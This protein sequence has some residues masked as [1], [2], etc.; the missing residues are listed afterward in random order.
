MQDRLLADAVLLLHGAFILFVLAGG[1]LV[2]RW[3]RLAWL[4]LP[5][6]AWAIW[7]EV[8][9]GI[10]PLTPLE[11]Q[12]RRAA[13]LAGFGGGFIEHYLLGAIYPEGLTRG[14]QIGLGGFALLL[15]LI[16]YARLLLR[17]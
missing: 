15:N 11:N 13:G 1:A 9:G 2:W 12:F 8:S 6:V 4:H 7:I 5:A 3:P 10:C 16:V 14:V 17:R